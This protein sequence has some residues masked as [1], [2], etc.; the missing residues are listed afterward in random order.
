MWLRR[1]VYVG[2]V[3][4]VLGGAEVELGSLVSVVQLGVVAIVVPA[5]I[6]GEEGGAGVEG[7]LG[8][9]GVEPG[10]GDAD[11]GGGERDDVGSVRLEG[12]D[13]ARVEGGLCCE[14]LVVY[15]DGGSFSVGPV[16]QDEFS[17]VGESGDGDGELLVGEHEE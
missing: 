14:E 9:G 16:E 12:G 11:E 8:V 6:E 3:D 4:P 13:D 1:R 5:S 10:S 7:S 2:V 15:P 17:L